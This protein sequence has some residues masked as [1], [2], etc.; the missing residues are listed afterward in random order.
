MSIKVLAGVEMPSKSEIMPKLLGRGACLEL[1][2]EGSSREFKEAG[3]GGSRPSSST[4]I[5]AVV[6]RLC[7]VVP[8]G[9]TKLASVCLGEG[10]FG[11]TML[12]FFLLCCRGTRL[13]ELLELVRRVLFNSLG[14]FKRWAFGFL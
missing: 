10:F 2:P 12:S 4:S 5:G 3:A 9:R 13:K 11:L 7:L 8:A 14:S 1:L 6:A